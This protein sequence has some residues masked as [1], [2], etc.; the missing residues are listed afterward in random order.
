MSDCKINNGHAGSGV[1]KPN[2]YNLNADRR[3]IRQ[4][5]MIEA[6]QQILRNSYRP[7]FDP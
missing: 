7:G 2:L 3:L 5:V 4:E 1:I 6:G